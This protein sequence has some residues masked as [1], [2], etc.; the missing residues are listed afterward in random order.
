MSDGSI[1]AFILRDNRVELTAA[2][3]R[4]HRAEIVLQKNI[5][6]EWPE[7]ITDH[8]SIEA[9]AHLKSKLP[10][11]KGRLGIAVPS[12]R[13]LMRIVEFPSI[14]PEELLGMAELQLDKI[15]PFP[16]DQMALAIEILH[17][18]AD[19]S[20]VL[21]AAIQHDYIDQLGDFLMKAGLYPQL[22]D[23]DVLGWWR[24]IKD[25]GRVRES[26]QE[27][28][29][30]LDDEHCAQMVIVRDGSPV[31]IRALDPGINL[32]H[33]DFASEIANEVEYTLMTL[34]S[35]WGPVETSGLTVWT[36]GIPPADLIDA[37][38]ASTRLTIQ[39]ANL[40]DLPPLSEGMSRRLTKSEHGAL[41]L[42]P[43]SWRR[44][45][46]SKRYQRQA[47]TISLAA[48]VVWG[49]LMGGLWY[50]AKNQKNNLARAQSDIS[51]LQREVEEVRQLRSQ[52]ESLQQYADR[53]FS[54]LECLRDIAQLLP[55]GV[56]ITS[57]TY[58]KASQINIR[59]EADTDSPIY[60]FLKKLE[61]SPLYSEVKAEGISTQ[62]R[63]GRSRSLFRVTMM[64]PT[65]GGG[66]ES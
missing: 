17:Q 36:R 66:Q 9:A 43:A 32:Q 4:K 48:L 1:I 49:I 63:G 25:E 57:M 31:I 27:I 18:T 16:S 19:A 58:N 47:M 26:G 42:A 13:V 15:S 37:I 21:I 55:E 23:V 50:L 39:T 29:V 11:V 56:E 6:L 54:G 60:D 64:L 33:P 52:V 2:Q 62:M 28:L 5:D 30:I 35:S 20:R 51:R 46:Q 14:D 10:P 12:D 8:R 24:L 45:I 41:D 53:S 3:R 7:T 61:Q 65:I 38:T 34:E 44:G 22:V 40:L 59:G